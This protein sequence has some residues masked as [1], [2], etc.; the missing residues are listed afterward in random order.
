MTDEDAPLDP[1]L[2]PV[3]EARLARMD[4]ESDFIEAIVEASAQGISYRQIAR[5][6]DLSFQRV[7]QIVKANRYPAK[8]GG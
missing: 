1:R 6:A 4:A 3:L 2:D 8:A 5:A 7:A